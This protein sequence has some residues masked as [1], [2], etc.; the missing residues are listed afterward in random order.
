MFFSV[1]WLS[2]GRVGVSELS[3]I[4]IY[5]ACLLSYAILSVNILYGKCNC[6]FAFVFSGA[7]SKTRAILQLKV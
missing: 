6:V 5:S 1:L 3:V 7:S 4:N 2:A